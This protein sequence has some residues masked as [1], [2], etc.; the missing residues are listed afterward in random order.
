[1]GTTWFASATAFGKQFPK[2]VKVITGLHLVKEQL[3]VAKNS[4]MAHTEGT[5]GRGAILLRLSHCFFFISGSH[6]KKDK[7]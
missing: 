2:A 4:G 7:M 5:D 3:L 6:R 1:M